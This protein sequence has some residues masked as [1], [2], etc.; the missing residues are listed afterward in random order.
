MYSGIGSPLHLASGKGLLDLV[1]LLVD[2]GADPLIKDPSGQIPLDRARQGGHTE[3]VEFLSPLPTPSPTSRQD[4]VDRPGFHFKPIP[5]EE[6]LKMGDWKGV[7]H[8]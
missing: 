5:M 3:V 4:F 1:Q 8:V 6:F 7:F 2:K